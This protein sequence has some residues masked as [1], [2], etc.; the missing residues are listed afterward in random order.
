MTQR[1]SDAV[2]NGAARAQ[3]LLATAYLA[4]G[5]ART[6]GFSRRGKAC[7]TLLAVV[8]TAG[9]VVKNLALRIAVVDTIG[10]TGGWASGTS[11]AR[12]CPAHSW[13]LPGCVRC[14]LDGSVA[15]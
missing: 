14:G 2:A 4:G 15:A 5:I 13:G 3:P 11:C 6:Q 10:N 8:V 12:R 1:V 9:M 7:R